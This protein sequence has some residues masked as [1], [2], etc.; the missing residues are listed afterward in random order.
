LKGHEERFPQGR[1]VFAQVRETADKATRA[2]ETSRSGLLEEST[3]ALERCERQ[4]FVR[5]PAIGGNVIPG[6]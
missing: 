3:E 2:R 1:R 5:R 6:C 4:P